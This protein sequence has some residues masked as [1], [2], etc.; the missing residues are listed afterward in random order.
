MS[1][2]QATIERQGGKLVIDDVTVVRT[3]HESVVW[4][5]DRAEETEFEISFP[6][7]DPLIHRSE[8]G[9]LERAVNKKALKGRYSYRIRLIR[10]DEDVKRKGGTRTDSPPDMDIQ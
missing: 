4:T 1:K 9:V 10:T 6:S 3:V 7:G 5:I 2:V 8:N